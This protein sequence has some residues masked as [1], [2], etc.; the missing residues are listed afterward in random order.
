LGLGPELLK[1]G[2]A[3]Q[4]ESALFCGFP[5]LMAIAQQFGFETKLAIFGCRY[6][7]LTFP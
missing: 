5:A 4:Q 6:G 2:F 7:M 1:R 3:C